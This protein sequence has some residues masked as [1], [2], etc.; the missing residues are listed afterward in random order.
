MGCRSTIWKNKLENYVLDLYNNQR[1]TFYEIAEIIKKEKK[2][3]I[4]R[5]AVRNFL[6]KNVQDNTA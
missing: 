4:T 6:N 5:E 1:K 2:I 3:A